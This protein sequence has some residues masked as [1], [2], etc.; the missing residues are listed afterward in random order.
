M[1]LITGS[2]RGH[3]CSC[4][5]QIRYSQTAAQRASTRR[6]TS[7]NQRAHENTCCFRNDFQSRKQRRA[8]RDAWSFW[9][10]EACHSSGHPATATDQ[11]PRPSRLP[12]QDVSCTPDREAKHRHE[13]PRSGCASYRSRRII[14]SEFPRCQQSCCQPL[15]HCL[16]KFLEAIRVIGGHRGASAANPA[17]Q[18]ALCQA[19]E[20]WS[21]QDQGSTSPIDEAAGKRGRYVNDGLS[22]CL[23]D[24]EYVPSGQFATSS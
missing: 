17:S 18:E 22:G 5:R 16:Q 10:D 3:R 8:C 21:G 11:D 12:G 7:C 14:R 2:G 9:Q 6:S 24:E 23:R 13:H 20:G 1:M 19:A 4:E 15:D